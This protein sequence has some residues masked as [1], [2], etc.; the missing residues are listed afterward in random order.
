MPTEQIFWRKL[1]FMT[2]KLGVFD[3]VWKNTFYFGTERVSWPV[4]KTKLNTT[5]HN[6]V[7]RQAQIIWLFCNIY[8]I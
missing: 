6:A 5:D 8:I 4:V 2:L 7:N 1:R 3:G